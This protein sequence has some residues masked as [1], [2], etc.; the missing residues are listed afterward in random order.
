M[1]CPC[2][3][4]AWRNRV[5]HS[6]MR[7]LREQRKTSA[8]P[9]LAVQLGGRFS[10]FQPFSGLFSLFKVK[11]NGAIRR[12]MDFRDSARIVTVGRDSVEPLTIELGFDGVSPC[13][14]SVCKS[15]TMNAL[16]PNRLLGQPNPV[17]VGQTGSNRFD[18]TFCRSATVFVAERGVSRRSPRGTPIVIPNVFGIPLLLGGRFSITK[19]YSALLSIIKVKRKTSK[20]ENLR[21]NARESHDHGFHGW[22]GS[23]SETRSSAFIREIRGSNVWIQS[24]PVYAMSNSGNIGRDAR[25]HRPEACSTQDQ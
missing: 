6:N 4:L 2:F 21:Q 25:C 10:S 23:D 12:E 18:A 9:L 5:K 19:L 17:K 16:Q 20:N 13:R 24:L 8:P 15:F 11:R 3:G 7:Q 14:K 22:H 1:F